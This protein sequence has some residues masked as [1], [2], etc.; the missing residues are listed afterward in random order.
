[1]LLFLI[2]CRL[3]EKGNIEAH[4][5]NIQ[6]KLKSKGQRMFVPEEGHLIHD[7]EVEWQ[8]LEKA[9]HNRELALRDELI[10]Q[11]RLE[12]LA[13]KFEKKVS[14]FKLILCYLC[15]LD[16]GTYWTELVINVERVLSKTWRTTVKCPS[17]FI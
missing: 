10:R 14:L 8:K 3:R 15:K 4:Y 9:E 6:A 5:F 16:H 2:H 13:Q 7:I 1:M 11:E 17:V 12:Q